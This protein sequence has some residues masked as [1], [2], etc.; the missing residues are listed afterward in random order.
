[1]RIAFFYALFFCSISFSTTSMAGIDEARNAFFKQQFNDANILLVEELAKN[2]DNQEAHFYR[3]IARLLTALEQPQGAAS[4]I[5]GSLSSL[6]NQFGFNIDNRSINNLSLT[7]PDV[8]PTN[9]PTGLTVQQY[10]E[11]SLITEINASLNENLQNIS[12]TFTLTITTSELTSFGMSNSIPLELDYAD[13]QVLKFVLG[14][15]N[16]NLQAIVSYDL[17]F[18]IDNIDSNDNFNSGTDLFSPNPSL[19][20]IRQGKAFYLEQ[21][22]NSIDTS[23]DAYLYAASLINLETDSQD[24]DFITINGNDAANEASFRAT[25][26]GIQNSLRTQAKVRLDDE[27]II[28]NL[29]KFFDATFNIRNNLPDDVL[30]GNELASNELPDQTLNG[31]FPNGIDNSTPATGAF[32]AIATVVEPEVEAKVQETEG[33]VYSV[34]LTDVKVAAN[35]T[36]T[37][38][39]V[40]VLT[41]T[42]SSTTIQR[43]D[44]SSVKIEP[45]TISVFNPTVGNTSTVTL[46]RGE[47]VTNISCSKSQN[48]L[49]KTKL[50]KISVLSN[51]CGSTQRANTSV[52]FTSNYSQDGLDGTLTISVTS[53]S[54]V[55]TDKNNQVTTVK[56]GEQKTIKDRVPRTSWVLPI[57]GGRIYGGKRNMLSWTAYPGAVSYLLE[58]NLPSPLFSEDNPSS[59]EFKNQTFEI[60]NFSLFDDL[61][62]FNIDLGKGLNGRVVEARIYALNSEGKIIGESVSS[63]RTTVIW[64]D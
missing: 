36:K 47:I 13:V 38:D 46:I 53:G 32:P 24:N 39:E 4:G 50:A 58:Y 8:L 57:D 33:S 59:Y 22:R 41:E 7:G 35:N 29:N 51:A 54:V 26:S 52:Q 60:T 27:E 2:P 1:M 23:I 61:V 19:L 43:D 55:V 11:Q 25:L 28:L 62:L 44:G 64:K 56:A 10:I 37:P 21:A 9:S 14:A 63:D 18:D 5:S 16:A 34:T 31:I 48:Y 15:L 6:L 49:V 17:N 40:V 45:K 20:T 3:A 42:E 12:P 30:T